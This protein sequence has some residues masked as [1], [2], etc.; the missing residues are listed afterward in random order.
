M[1]DNFQ[2]KI[3]TNALSTFMRLTNEVLKEFLGK[4]FIIYLDDIL[5]FGKTLKEHL[6]HISMVF[7]KLREEKLLINLK[8]C[9][10]IKELVY[11]GFVVLA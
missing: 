9:G 4:F 8:K 5:I 3:R 10:F 6:I 7:Y 2:D 1:V 11:L